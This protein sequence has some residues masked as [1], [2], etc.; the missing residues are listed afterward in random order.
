[1]PR[2]LGSFD[3]HIVIAGD[4]AKL[5]LLGSALLAGLGKSCR[6]DDDATNLPPRAGQH[7]L[8][9]RC[10]RNR[11]HST[12]DTL[13]KIV[14]RRQARPPADVVALR[15]D[16][17]ELATVA[18]VLQVGHHAGAEGSRRRRRAYNGNGTWPK[19]AFHRCS[20]ARSH[21]LGHRSLNSPACRTVDPA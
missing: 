13:W 6:K 11:Q 3:H 21:H 2:Q 5:L 14:H 17:V 19:Q 12:I 7:G 18:G 16:E 20:R 1:M 10:T 4:A 15:I 9:H 8:H